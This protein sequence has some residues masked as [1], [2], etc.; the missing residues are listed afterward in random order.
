MIVNVHG[1]DFVV[2]SGKV[3]NRRCNG[4]GTIQEDKQQLARF[5]EKEKA[6]FSVFR[7]MVLTSYVT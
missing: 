3:F 7:F 1:V 2:S 4:S 5:A 6:G